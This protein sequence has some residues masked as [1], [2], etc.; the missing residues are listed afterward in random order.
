M[1]VNEIRKI[2]NLPTLLLEL[3]VGVVL[4]YSWVAGQMNLKY[5]PL[6]ETVQ[7]QIG[8]QLQEK[9]G[10]ELDRVEL[11]EV[12]ALYREAKKDLNVKAAEAY[13]EIVGG[14]YRDFEAFEKYCTENDGFEDEEM[15]GIYMEILEKYQWEYETCDAYETILDSAGGYWGNFKYRE[16]TKN[17]VLKKRVAELSN[18]DTISTLPYQVTMNMKY[19]MG[20]FAWVL[21][22]LALILVLPYLASDCRMRVYPVIA[23]T[24]TGRRI[25]VYQMTA[26][27]LSVG[28]LL[29]VCN[30]A[31]YLV[32]RMMTP[33]EPF[34]NCMVPWLWFDW[35]WQQYFRIQL[36]MIDIGVLG[37]SMIFFFLS[38][39]CR[40]IIGLVVM[41]IPCWFAGEMLS[42]N[43][44]NR[45]FTISDYGSFYS[46]VIGQK[47]F[48]PVVTEAVLVA[49]GALLLWL[50]YRKRAAEDIAE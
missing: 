6:F 43:Y 8:I 41:A 32:Y 27:F 31:F 37:L 2:W 33:Y 5:L 39:L 3:V 12:E 21:I 38:S 15:Y 44:F 45:L 20:N 35:T 18:R 30:G 10:D 23:S 25:V 28:I 7:L 46:D 4:L 16:G 49:A 47:P 42:M 11:Q 19:V 40:T 36:F 13:P 34:A 17:Q 22:I 24:K 26:M 14:K 29:L 9:Y 48:L 50:L 1:L